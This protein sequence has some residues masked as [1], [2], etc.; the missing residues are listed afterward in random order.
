MHAS[1][2]DLVALVA[3]DDDILDA[4]VEAAVTDADPDDVT[5]D[6]GAGWTDARLAWLRRFHEERRRGFDAH[7]DEVTRAIVVDH[8]IVGAV[9]IHRTPDD[10]SVAEIGIW[11]VRSKRGTGVGAAA[12]VATCELAAALGI[13]I[14]TATT[15]SANTAARR[16]LDRLAFQCSVDGT[17]VTATRALTTRT[18]GVP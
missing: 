12:I 4:L 11:V 17:G 6:L 15:T 7:H 13:R 16:I 3:V 9:R 8:S 18:G 2:P 1:A 5:P 14:A 10:P